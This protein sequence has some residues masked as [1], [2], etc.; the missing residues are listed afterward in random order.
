MAQR[1]IAKCFATNK[2]SADEMYVNIQPLS[3][4]AANNSV[5]EACVEP[6]E[7]VMGM[8]LPHGGHLTPGSE[9]NRSGKSYKI[10]SC[11]VDPVTQ[12]LE[13]DEIKRLAIDY[14]Q[15]DL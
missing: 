15:G 8:A 5:Y 6:G 11:E 14:H 13:Y 3:G 7:T 1:W 4:A 12:K 2:I 9:F 10:V